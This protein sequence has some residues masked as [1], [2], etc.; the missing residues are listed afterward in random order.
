MTVPGKVAIP[1]FQ[2]KA[3]NGSST[4]SSVFTSVFFVSLLLSLST[5]CLVTASFKSLLSFTEGFLSSVTSEGRNNG[6][7]VLRCG[8]G[9]DL[10][11]R[12]SAQN[13]AYMFNVSLNRFKQLV[14]YDKMLI[15]WVWLGWTGKYYDFR[16]SEERRKYGNHFFTLKL[17]RCHGKLTAFPVIIWLLASF[18]GLSPLTVGDA[19]LLRLGCLWKRGRFPVTTP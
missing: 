14:L 11:T 4:T 16:L 7:G 17:C 3:P 9:S 18:S 6:G 8:K 5:D 10:I 15:D 2:S 19:R 1:S 13:Q 12:F